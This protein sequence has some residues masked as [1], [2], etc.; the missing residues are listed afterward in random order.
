MDLIAELSRREEIAM[1]LGIQDALGSIGNAKDRR[2]PS[3][4]GDGDF[5]RNYV[6]SDEFRKL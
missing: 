3:N 4:G 2:R 5:L 6:E 1:H